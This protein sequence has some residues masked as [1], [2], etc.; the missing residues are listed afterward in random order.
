MRDIWLK[1]SQVKDWQCNVNIDEKGKTVIWKTFEW[2]TSKEKTDNALA[3]LSKR[4][5][6]SYE[7]HLNERQP[8]K[9]IAIK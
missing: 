2:K 4:Q 6:N 5:I 3:I 8:I 7:R 9:R 1:D